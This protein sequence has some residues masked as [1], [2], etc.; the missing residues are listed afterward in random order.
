M[1]GVT[2]YSYSVQ[3]IYTGQIQN[4][5][6]KALYTKYSGHTVRWVKSYAKESLVSTNINY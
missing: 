3:F 2:D 6:L 5:Y 4:T 1:A